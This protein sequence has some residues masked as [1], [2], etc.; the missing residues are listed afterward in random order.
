MPACDAVIATPNFP[1]RDGRKIL[2]ISVT[3]SNADTSLYMT[4]VSAGDTAMPNLQREEPKITD[5]RTTGWGAAAEYQAEGLSNLGIIQSSDVARA[6]LE[7]QNIPEDKIKKILGAGAKYIL[8]TTQNFGL[9]KR[10]LSVFMPTLSLKTEG[11]GILS[12]SYQSNSSAAAKNINAQKALTAFKLQKSDGTGVE[13]TN[14][15]VF[16][17]PM[18][19][20]LECVGCPYIDMNQAYFVDL[21]TNTTLD[22]V[23]I[24]Q[25]YSHSISAAGFTTKITLAYSGN[26]MY[27]SFMSNV[28]NT[29]HT[30]AE[31]SPEGE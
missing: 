3:D 8:N 7:K 9:L 24:V 26:A 16:I 29:M 1:P 28:S 14:L 11:S 4:A 18:T 12:I 17:M 10:N 15:P 21:G 23:Y 13:T 19:L 27:Q 30:V 5:L 20:E 6:A 2:K 31:I 25:K 22:N